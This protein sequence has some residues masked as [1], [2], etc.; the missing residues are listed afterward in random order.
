MDPEKPQAKCCMVIPARTGLIASGALNIMCI[1]I[2][3]LSL[4]KGDPASLYGAPQ[5]VVDEITIDMDKEGG[6]YK[7]WVL[8]Q[9]VIWY[10]YVLLCSINMVCLVRMIMNDSFTT[11]RTLFRSYTVTALFSFFNVVMGL[12][13]FY[14]TPPEVFMFAIY[15]SCAYTGNKYANE[16]DN[17]KD[18]KE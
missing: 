10:G 7:F 18:I 14:Y 5:E 3:V 11:R 12:L 4:S 17:T 2:G 6:Q 13:G 1:L 15:A 16:L 9:S 8:M